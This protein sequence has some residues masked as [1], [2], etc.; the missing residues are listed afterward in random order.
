MWWWSYS[1]LAGKLKN[2]S[3]RYNW[4]STIVQKPLF[5]E[6]VEHHLMSSVRNPAD[7]VDYQKYGWTYSLMH[8][9]QMFQ[10]S[11]L[12]WRFQRRTQ[13][14]NYIINAMSIISLSADQADQ[15][16][17][18]ERTELL[19][20]IYQCNRLPWILRQKECDWVLGLICKRKI[21]E[22]SGV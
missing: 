13:Q 17:T 5:A 4:R 20:W 2:H 6:R 19:S 7:S 15:L 14:Q 21:V 10:N 22:Y 3:H 9:S 1:N 12:C 11:S 18:Y 16:R 8:F